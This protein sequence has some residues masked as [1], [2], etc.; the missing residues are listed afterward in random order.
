M[1]SLPNIL[2]NTLFFL[3]GNAFFINEFITYLRS[4]GYTVL[5]FFTFFTIPFIPPT[6]FLF[7]LLPYLAI[8]YREKR[9][10]LTIENPPF[11]RNKYLHY[12]TLIGTALYV[13]TNIVFLYIIVNF[14]LEIKFFT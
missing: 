8:R 14:F 13:L 12:A 10:N 4:G 5:L 3:S 7:T 9:H 11:T 1:F 6:A 2:F